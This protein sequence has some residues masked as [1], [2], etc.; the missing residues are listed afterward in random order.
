MHVLKV[1]VLEQ[2][3]FFCDALYCSS[4]CM[5]FQFLINWWHSYSVI[6]AY[7][8]GLHP[9]KP[10]QPNLTSFRKLQYTSK[11]TKQHMHL[12][13]CLILEPQWPQPTYLSL[14]KKLE[15][16]L[17]FHFFTFA[18]FSGMGKGGGGGDKNNFSVTDP[19]LKSLVQKN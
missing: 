18:H 2:K 12:Y 3:C 19:S 15:N 11:S 9:F 14:L 13:I 17:F 4:L 6:L 7:C 8:W 10:Q 16:I 1:I 5:Y